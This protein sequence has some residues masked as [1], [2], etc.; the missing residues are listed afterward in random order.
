[1]TE[2]PMQLHVQVRDRIRV[3]HYSI[4]T[5]QAYWGWIKRFIFFNDKRAFCLSGRWPGI[6]LKFSDGDSSPDNRASLGCIEKPASA[7]SVRM[8]RFDLPRAVRPVLIEG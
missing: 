6:Y 5:K 2:Q 8:K 7:G 1:M 3:N 4:L